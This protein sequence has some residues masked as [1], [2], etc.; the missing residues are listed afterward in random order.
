MNPDEVFD[1]M[2]IYGNFFHY[3]LVIFLVGSAFLVF[4]YLW[5]KGRLN[6]DEEAKFQMMCEEEIE[7]GDRTHGASGKR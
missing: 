2:G 1:A 5:K 4:L 7:Q 3:A 6:M